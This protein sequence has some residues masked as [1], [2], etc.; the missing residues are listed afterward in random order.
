MAI[1]NY[2]T[3]SHL[4]KV[5][6]VLD[7][8]FKKIE[9]DI[10]R[11]ATKEYVDEI[12]DKK[13]DIEQGTE[14]AGMVLTVN[15]DGN[16]VTSALNVAQSDW[17]EDDSTINSY[18]LN[19]PAI[20]A[21]EGDNS[22]MEGNLTYTA[23]TTVTL[24]GDANATEYNVVGT[25]LS[26]DCVQLNKTVAVAI[27]RKSTGGGNY[28]W[29]FSNTLSSEPLDSVVCN[30]YSLTNRYVTTR[31]H[32][33]GYHTKVFGLN[34]HAE[35]L[36]TVALQN[37]CHAEGQHTVA[38]GSSQHV[39]GK[40]NVLDTSG[41]YADIVG[42]GSSFINRSNAYTLDWFGNGW[43]AGK[44]SAG[45]VES[46]A[47]P[48][49]ANDLVTKSY[50]DSVTTGTSLVGLTDTTISSPNDGQTLVYNSSTSKW[51]NGSIGTRIYFTKTGNTTIDGFG[52]VD[53]YSYTVIKDGVTV[54]EN[55]LSVLIQAQN[56]LG[57]I[58][59]EESL[60]NLQWLNYTGITNF[61]FLF[62]VQ[63]FDTTAT[64]QNVYGIYLNSNYCIGSSLPMANYQNATTSSAGLMSA[65]DKEK[66]DGI[67]LQSLTGLINEL[68]DDAL[69]NADASEVEY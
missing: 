7:P 39:Q 51:V 15:E 26:G 23:P 38:M 9:S 29:E 24:S 56:I 36:D 21:G 59:D 50:L 27:Q 42:N 17:N 33:E 20:R 32:A 8:R 34:S 22:I 44:V 13:V 12:I 2:L 40:Y 52:Q 18:I 41:V 61:G 3:L 54:T 10:S 35:G 5:L 46:P 63:Q 14:N 4:R 48:T 45:T 66:L 57:I 16:V 31:G 55:P 67:T 68:I 53:V 62:T 1:S 58:I 28:V 65:S 30:R 60:E 43:F 6:A 37:S 19:K 47:V 69:T 25:L 49:A 64:V 11:T